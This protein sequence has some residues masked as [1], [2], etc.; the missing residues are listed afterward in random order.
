M[1]QAQ[2]EA[3]RPLTTRLAL[4]GR[5][6]FDFSGISTRRIAQN[7]VLFDF[8]LSRAF[9]I[10]HNSGFAP[11][12]CRMAAAASIALGA[13]GRAPNLGRRKAPPALSALRQHPVPRRPATAGPSCRVRAAAPA[14]CRP[15][16]CRVP[17]ALKRRVL[18]DFEVARP[19][20]IKHF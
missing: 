13:A 18:F 2:G 14:T 5:V 11:L 15:R 6:V 7:P 8:L 20:E 19:R 3:S 16:D 12:R 1:C 17:N 4:C 10:K 9:K